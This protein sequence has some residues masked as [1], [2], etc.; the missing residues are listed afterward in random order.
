M[1][2]NIFFEEKGGEAQRRKRWRGLKRVHDPLRINIPENRGESEMYHYDAPAEETRTLIY[3]L[4]LLTACRT[5]AAA[6]RT[7]GEI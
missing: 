6:G 4:L 5:A 2:S 1:A 3:L 7:L